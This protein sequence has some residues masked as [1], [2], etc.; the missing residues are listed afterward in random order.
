LVSLR[1]LNQ[2][3]QGKERIIATQ[4]KDNRCETMINLERNALAILKG[5]CEYESEENCIFWQLCLIKFCS[6]TSQKMDWVQN[7][8][9]K[10]MVA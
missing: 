8:E 4:D 9:Y 2:T 6:S 1:D 7:Q 10:G 3:V 5:S